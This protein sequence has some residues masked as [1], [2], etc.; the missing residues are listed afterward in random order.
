MATLKDI[1][2]SA[3]VSV[4]SVSYVINGKKQLSEETT[5]RIKKGH[6]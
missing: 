5:K 1:A 4:A 3:G 2:K 6:P